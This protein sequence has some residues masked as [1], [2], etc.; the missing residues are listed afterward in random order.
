MF[1][2]GTTTTV[3]Y[4]ATLNGQTATCSF[5]VTVV[6]GSLAFDPT[7]CYKIVNKNSGKAMEVSQSLTTDLAAIVQNTV[8]NLT[9]RRNQQWQI[10][11][12]GAN[13]VKLTAR[14]SDKSIASSNNGNK[15]DVYQICYNAS[16]NFKDWQIE[17]LGSGFYRIKHRQGNKYLSVANASTANGAKIE[18]RNWVAANDQMWQ[19]IETT[20]GST[21]ASNLCANSN[22]MA[23]NTGNTGNNNTLTAKDGLHLSISPNPA[24]DKI[25]IS[26]ANETDAEWTIKMVNTVGQTVFIQTGQYSSIFNID[27]QNFK[28]GLYIIEYQVDGNRKI[29]KVLVQH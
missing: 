26:I 6:A 13:N 21:T 15:S 23:F 5:T 8:S 3:T 29:E 9:T 12:V 16:G 17:C 4:T 25:N 22:D 10:A 18:I 27:A 20:C 2:A 1:T 7:K 11:S 24:T 19:I 14:H 28:S